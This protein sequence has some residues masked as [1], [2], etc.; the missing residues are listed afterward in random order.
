MIEIKMHDGPARLGKYSEMK[1]PA[2][3]GI[4]D[5]LPLI[6]DEPMAYNV[7]KPLA[8]WSVNSTVENARLN[9]QNGVVVVHGSK[10]PDLRVQCANELEELGYNVL[11]IANP[12][13][14][15]KRSRDLVEILVK[16]RESINPNSAIYFPFAEPAFIPLL[17]Y[18]GVDF[19]DRV[20]GDYYA[21]LNTL[22]T[23]TMKYDLEVYNIFE[24]TQEEL[25]E[26]NKKTLEFSVREVQEHIKNGTLRNL[27][28]E[29]CCSSPEA[30]TALR[31]LDRDYPD[32]LDKYTQL[33]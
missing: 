2:I 24:M 8:T 20:A 3:F 15:M 18:I 11:M 7:P 9:D 17:A 13:E 31:L 33:H 30:M 25:K 6:K 22:L 29:R 26:Y 28:E 19:F 16:V 4:N 21:G 12:E 32:F 5:E 14:L 10:Y 27:V 23:P 1:T